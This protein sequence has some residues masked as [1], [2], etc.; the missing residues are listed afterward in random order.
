MD[1]LFALLNGGE[2]AHNQICVIFKE[3]RSAEQ[4]FFLR[5]V[6]AQI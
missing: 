6:Y 5:R 2:E 1:S 4:R 3:K